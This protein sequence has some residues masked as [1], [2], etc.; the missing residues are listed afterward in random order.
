MTRTG[1]VVLLVV[2][3]MLAVASVLLPSPARAAEF[4]RYLNLPLVNRDAAHGTGG[5][6][7]DLPTDVPTLGKLLGQARGAGVAP[8]SYQA[9]LAQYWL[10]TATSEA[11][12]ELK[13]WNPRTGAMA[14]REVLI[15]SYRYYE[16]FQL[17]HRELQWAGM[18][19][20]VG[21]DFGGGLVDFELFS[22]P[23]NVKEIGLAANAVV[24]AVTD[25][26]G[27]ALRN[28]LPDGLLAIADGGA[29]ITGA[30]LHYILGMIM[31]MQKNIF[32]DLMPMHA[33]YVDKGLPAIAEMRDAG[34]FDDEIYRAGEAVAAKNPDRIA[35]GNARLLR[36]EQGEVIKRQ[37]DQVR[38]HRGKVGAAITYLSTVAGSPSVAGVK[39]PRSMDPVVLYSSTPDG[40]RLKIT[41]PLPDW[42]WSVYS[43][44]WRYISDELLPKYKFMVNHRW[45]QL[46]ATLEVPY[47]RQFESHRPIMNIPQIL[48]AMADQIRVEVVK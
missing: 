13:S 1:R 2:T 28:A 26:G 35:A 38:N 27:P 30:D 12:I 15:K 45:P 21:A 8:R 47:E 17:S 46:R 9:L 42:D 33:A 4:D 10:A 48:Y 41:T 6:H 25:A 18:G 44:R 14:N 29:K 22:V 3:M 36:R 43:E 32:S 37:W 19:G 20:Q 31:V 7:P 34:L 24:K 5:L 40:R 16:N 23:F 39:P 11:G